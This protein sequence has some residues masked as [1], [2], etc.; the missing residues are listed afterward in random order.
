MG[1][2]AGDVQNWAILI[3]NY[4][5]Q[6]ASEGIKREFTQSLFDSANYTYE[7]RDG[8]ELVDEVR[9]SLGDYFSSKKIA[10]QVSVLQ[11][12]SHYEYNGIKIQLQT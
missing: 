11:S 12:C 2:L 10:A 4:I 9:E 1:T 6:L 7:D 3:Q 5:L 8:D